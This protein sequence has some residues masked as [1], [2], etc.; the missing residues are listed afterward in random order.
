MDGHRITDV[1]MAKQFV[2][3]GKALFTLK[4]LKTDRHVTFKVR[5]PKKVS[6]GTPSTITHFV[7]VRDDADG[8]GSYS[9]LGTINAAGAFYHGRKSLVAHDHWRTNAARWLF[10][11][12]A[13]DELPARS[14]L[15]HE[16]RCGK[17]GR[18]LTVPES[19]A[20]GIGPECAKKSAGKAQTP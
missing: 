19:I 17:C 6:A 7:S 10:E 18:V 16:G 15:W 2:F 1:T 9:Y 12:L 13:R 11:H 4:S 14:E 3:A 8:E 5:K 20:S